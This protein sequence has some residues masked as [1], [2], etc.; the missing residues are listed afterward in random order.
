MFRCPFGEIQICYK[1]TSKP[2]RCARSQRTYMENIHMP[3]A[4]WSASLQVPEN[5]PVYGKRLSG[6]LHWN[7]WHSAWALKETR[8]C[9]TSCW[10]S[11]PQH[12]PFVS[13]LSS[14]CKNKPMLLSTQSRVFLLV[15][16][17]V[18]ESLTENKAE[19]KILW[20]GGITV[21]YVW[22]RLS[23]DAI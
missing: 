8:R 4:Y 18:T 23:F 16:S 12:R 1:G 14:L 3:H 5:L 19:T 21:R 6:A 17:L 9:S 11:S 7:S 20:Y 2:E 13:R 22:N 15:V 10:N